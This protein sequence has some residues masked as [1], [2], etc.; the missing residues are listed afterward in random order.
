MQFIACA[1]GLDEVAGS[2]MV[3]FA[4]SQADTAHGH[5]MKLLAS[6]LADYIMLNA[7]C[8]LVVVV[9]VLISAQA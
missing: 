1:H 4:I 3:A 5:A 2:L 6:I 9:S 8:T 7:N